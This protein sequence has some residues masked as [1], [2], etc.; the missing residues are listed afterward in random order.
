MIWPTNKS[1][2]P[3]E[4]G[5][6]VKL[7]LIYKITRKFRFGAAV[8]SPSWNF[9]KDEFG[10]ILDYTLT[11]LNTGAPV[12]ESFS[13]VSPLSQFDCRMKSPWR[14]LG[15]ISHLFKTGDLLGFISGEVEYIDYGKSNFDLTINSNN[16]FDQFIEE[17]LND[18]ISVLLTS[19]INLRLGGEVAY[20]KYRFH[21]GAALLGSPYQNSD[22]YDFNPQYN[23]GIGYRGDI[24]YFD[25]AVTLGSRDTRY[26]PYRLVDADRQPVVFNSFSRMR[27]SLTFGSKI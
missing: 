2:H 25:L 16:P 7:G 19:A 14:I 10:T 8:H 20:K 23:A 21:L 13:A 26:S 22:T 9:L 24:R 3:Q 27:I 4:F 15:G 12:T 5:V 6:N 1:C 17:D 11:S 18:E